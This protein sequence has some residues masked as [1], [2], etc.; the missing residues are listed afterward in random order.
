MGCGPRFVKLGPGGRSSRIRYRITELDRYLAQC[1][2]A[3]TA[4]PG[5]ATSNS[6]AAAGGAT[7]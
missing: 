4:D 7:T 6:A 2:R 5:R 1:E 3:S